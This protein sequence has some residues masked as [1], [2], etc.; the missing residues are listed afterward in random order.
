MRYLNRLKLTVLI[1]A[2]VSLTVTPTIAAQKTWTG[3]GDSLWSSGGNWSPSGVPTASDNVVF[4]NV[5]TVVTPGA[6]A[7]NNS[8]D[9][10]FGA[11]I[12]SLA[13]MNTNE[14]HN[15]S[16]TN[17]LQV[18]SSSATD[19]AFVADDGRPAVMFVGSGQ[20]DG[21][22]ANV[23][24]TIVGSSLVV[25]NGNADLSVM[26]ING[27]DNAG[28]WAT[29]DL[30]GLD[31]FSCTVSNVQVAV[32]TG[33][34][35]TRPHGRLL[36]ART[37]VVTAANLLVG[38]VFSSGSSQTSQIRL[39]QNNQVNVDAVRVGLRKMRGT[40][41]FNDGLT[42][43]TAVFR[44]AAGTG[45]VVAWEVGD[46]NGAGGSSS[47]TIGIMDF[48]GGALDAQVE[49]I[50]VGRGQEADGQ[51]DGTGTLTIGGGTVDV[52]DL[53]LGIQQFASRSVGRGTLNLNNDPG[54]GPAL[55]KVNNDVT[56]AVQLAGNTDVV[57]STAT[58]N[59]NG[60]T[61]AVAGDIV[62]GAGLSTLSLSSGGTV[63]LQPSGD[64]TAGNISVDNLVIS[65]GTIT[66]YDTLSVS[67][68]ALVGPATQFTVYAGQSIA[69]SGEGVV[70][71]LD[72]VGDL[73]LRGTTTMDINK[74]GSILSADL[75]T[76]SGTADL[77]GTLNVTLSGDAP[78]TAGDSFLL[79]NL[80]TGLNAFTTVNLPALDPGLGWVNNL[81]V[82][83]S[84]LVSTVGSAPSF[85]TQPSPA[86]VTAYSNST[87][88]FKAVAV[89]DYP[90]HYRWQVDSVN[91]AGAT[92]FNVSIA[93]L[94]LS[95]GSTYTLRVQASNSIGTALSDPVSIT[96]ITNPAADYTLYL[97]TFS[98]AG[99]VP[100]NGREPE[101]TP[102]CANWLAD[103]G[104][105]VTGGELPYPGLLQSYLPFTPQ[106]GHVY[107]FSVDINP[108]TGG[109][110]W[111]AFGFANAP[112]VDSGGFFVGASAWMLYRGDRS[113]ISTFDDYFA[114]GQ[115][116]G[117]EWNP[118]AGGYVT[119]TIVLDTTTGNSNAN[120][121]WTISF[122][123]DGVL[124]GA[125]PVH[126]YASNP[127]ISFIGVG[128]SGGVTGEFDNLR[129]TDSAPV[130]TSP[131]VPVILPATIEVYS[132]NPVS[133]SAL[134]A[135]ACPLSYQWRHEGTNIAGATNS[136][137]VFSNIQSFQAGN[138]S[139]VVTNSFGSSTSSVPGTL[140][141]MP[142]P[143]Q[144]FTIYKDS[145]AGSGGNMLNG[146]NPEI[147][148]G[149]GVWLA[150]GSMIIDTNE[151][152]TPS[153]AQNA[154]AFLPF[155]P[156]VG[157]VYVLS[158]DLN[159]LTGGAN[160]VDLGFTYDPNVNTLIPEQG[161]GPWM[162]QR[163]D[164]SESDFFSLAYSIAGGSGDGGNAVGYTTWK[165]ILDTTT[166]DKFTGWTASLVKGVPGSFGR[167]ISKHVYTSNPLITHVSVGSASGVGVSGNVDNFL[168]TDNKIPLAISQSGGN[169]TLTWSEG[170]L[171]EAPAVTG[172]WTT[173][174]AAS[175][176]TFSPTA[177]QKFYRV[178]FE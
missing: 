70:G 173:N 154:S 54:V 8:V 165:I 97:D 27:T 150:D 168:L 121:G 16:L 144:A 26:Q 31:V 96:V 12:N 174:N 24:A 34:A 79:L 5:G 162:L 169:V 160:W 118:K 73:Q 99:S 21:I 80:P 142:D 44:N 101:E 112:D 33:V 143:V 88:N 49:R 127:A 63:D 59:L 90:V 178:Q 69:P 25:S 92:N 139:V 105:V 177:P 163:A 35:S 85:T 55:L 124:L 152:F 114:G 6:G 81:L 11:S 170:I 129:F 128:G 176:Y 52:D 126:T 15:T 30:A 161:G 56:M 82:D 45:R 38:D 147:S 109:A 146:R 75:L 29:L 17:P 57:G 78:L 83:G 155:A 136:S 14:Y 148:Y 137:L 64:A 153:G 157:H 19:V 20:A 159:P 87:F 74:T 132:N 89:G 107:T 32:D 71:P 22:A 53:E 104:M 7:V 131:T 120:S 149:G 41:N 37:N 171:L 28:Y 42:A 1:S 156:K 65:D 61:L 93:A 2:S 103:A 95:P 108:L 130:P 100:L 18:I 113:G 122:A 76:V 9:V 110:N 116:L 134:V 84:I 62:D 77:G 43:P 115:N 164:R 158:A 106:W 111:L 3:A 60:G 98:D 86:A 123:A 138:Y 151:L 172:P 36:L 58:I 141:V 94:G 68:V 167:I 10:G 67:N 50:T 166:G 140:V 117:P 72:V 46:I 125:S 23:Y 13:Y 91:V 4:T 39:G 119:F 145:F 66:N 47:Q 175:P 135:G 40:M 51:G 133:F 48:T 102:G